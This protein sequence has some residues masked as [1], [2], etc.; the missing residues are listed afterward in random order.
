MGAMA[1][2]P[3]DSAASE[4]PFCRSSVATSTAEARMRDQISPARE[5]PMPRR[6]GGV[7]EW[8]VIGILLVGDQTATVW[9]SGDPSSASHKLLAFYFDALSLA[10]T[11]LAK[12]FR[13][14]CQPCRCCSS[15]CEV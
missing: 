7:L 13:M 11:C 1:G 4:S 5:R 2:G 8:V 9:R 6:T 15:G 12:L 14:A 3:A 10:T